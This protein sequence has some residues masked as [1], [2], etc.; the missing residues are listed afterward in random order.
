MNGVSTTREPHEVIPSS[1][2]ARLGAVLAAPLSWLV[3][4]PLV[5]LSCGSPGPASIPVTVNR[6]DALSP[7]T[8]PAFREARALLAAGEVHGARAAFQRL[9]DAAPDNVLV[10][11]WL[12][13]AD[14]AATRA[15]LSD[16]ARAEIDLARRFAAE[17]EAHPTVTNWILA[18]RLARDEAQRTRY[19]DQAEA[20][21][22]Q[23]AW[24]H[25]A[26]A[27]VAARAFDWPVARARIA[28]AK[29]ADPGHLW[30]WWLEAWIATR[31]SSL[32]ESASLLAGFVARAADDP[33]VDPRLLADS[34]LDLALVWT[35]R[36]D[37]REARDLIAR[38]DPRD[39][40]AS[41]RLAALS[42]IEQALGELTTALAA[43]QDAA[44]LAPDD[45]LPIVQ[46]AL[47]YDEW[48]G[49]AE[50]AEAA[51]KLVLERARTSSQVT[52]VLERTRAGIRLE[53]FQARR[54]ARAGADADATTRDPER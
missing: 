29:E 5:S 38:I 15:E 28:R 27:F 49:D 14:L 21:D 31:T 45:I 23:C 53:R 47:L 22:P 11:V 39:V 12:Q 8:M 26:R 13:E 42:S 1:R 36:G 43:A 46:Q 2:R 50:R 25:Y 33:R 40:D 9:F 7:E 18:A 3:W 24:V 4:L 10:G 34:R 51:W 17:A 16:E 35:L 30:T 54:A 20:L 48:L 19:L 6:Y 32:D 52:S 44:R 37:T 41:R